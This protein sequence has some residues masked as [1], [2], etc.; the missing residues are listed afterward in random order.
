MSRTSLLTTCALAAS[1]LAADP[2]FARL[3]VDG[4]SRGGRCSDSRP[5][6]RV[7]VRTPW[8]SLGAAVRM[9]KGTVLVRRGSYPA[10]SFDDH[11][12][13][14]AFRAYG[15][16]RPSVGLVSIGDS[17]GFS[18]RG[19]RFRSEVDLTN[20][21]HCSFSDNVTVQR[22]AGLRTLSGYTVTGVRDARWARNSVR[23]GMFGIHFRWGGV[24][25]VQ[26]VGNRFEKLGGQGIHLQQAD[27]VRIARNVFSDIVPRRDMD[28]AA[29]A[30]AVQALG[31]SRDT[32]F[33]G[34][35]VS[36]GRG[37]LLMFAPADVGMR[38][39]QL[40]V[41]VKNNVFTGRDFGVRVFSSP[42]IRIVHN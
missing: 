5:P 38:A 33:D 17:A 3:V 6:A 27:N 7:S 42:G 20:V 1:L 18:F 37:F 4:R 15:R 13:P 16:E 9:A 29:H 31:P 24:K 23:R 32:V 36:G 14:I 40:G 8:C 26:I 2:A 35:R 41:M 10:L 22:P 28:P 34:N 21:S 25:N 39:G 12:T 11:V 19:F 30:D